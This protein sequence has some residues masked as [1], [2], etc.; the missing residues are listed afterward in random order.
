MSKWKEQP[1]WTCQNACGGCSWS[2]RLE[3]VEGW[4][5]ERVK[6]KTVLEQGY[7]ILNCPE[8]VSDDTEK[9]VVEK[10][11]LRRLTEHDKQAIKYLRKNGRTYREIQ[12]A[13]GWSLQTISNIVR[14][15]K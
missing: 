9:P 8:Y 14:D 10:K 2:K 12:E 3:P 1:C 7:R 15:R 4:K 11:K 5:A 6:K 13:T